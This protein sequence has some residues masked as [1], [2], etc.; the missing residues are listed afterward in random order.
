MTRSSGTLGLWGFERFKDMGGGV[1]H[2]SVKVPST[3]CEALIGQA[4]VHHGYVAFLDSPTWHRG[5]GCEL[6]MGPPLLTYKSCVKCGKI[7]TVGSK[8]G[9][10]STVDFGVERD[11]KTL[12]LRGCCRPLQE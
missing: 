2:R 4:C 11:F 3:K 5:I 8:G 6:G 12:G 9:Q 1:K 10:S 7:S